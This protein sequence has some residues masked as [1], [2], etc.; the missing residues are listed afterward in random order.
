VEHVAFVI[1]TL[2]EAPSIGVVI[3]SIPVAELAEKGYEAAVYVV[4]GRSVDHTR[5]IA[6]DKGAQVLLEK[7]KGKE[8]ALKTA[9]KAIDVDYIII[10]DGDNTY[11]I[12]VATEMLRLLQTYDVVIESRLKGL[13]EPGAMTKRNAIGNT[14]LTLLA[15]SLFS[16]NVPDVCTGLWGYRGD[17]IRRLELEAHGF[18]IEADMFSECARNRLRMV[19]LPISYRARV[20]QAKLASF[21]DGVKIGAFLVRKWYVNRTRVAQEDETIAQG[22]AGY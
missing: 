16:A 15:R 8:I 4:D 10:V 12:S 2:N 17:V 22:V 1:P 3:A 6:A 21:R 13:A 20:D 7:R 5:E 11:P 14:P 19:E 18:E 9:F